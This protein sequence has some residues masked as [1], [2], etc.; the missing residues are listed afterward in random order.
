MKQE[1]FEIT[2]EHNAGV[3]IGVADA[4]GIYVAGEAIEHDNSH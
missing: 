2:V 3:E 4:L 1:E